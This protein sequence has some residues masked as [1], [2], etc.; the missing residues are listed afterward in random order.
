MFN[1]QQV[2]DKE[3]IPLNKATAVNM[4]IKLW[5]FEDEPDYIVNLGIHCDGKTFNYV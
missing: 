5:L 1:F 2:L 3:E 4:L